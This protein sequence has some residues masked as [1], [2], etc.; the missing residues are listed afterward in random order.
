MDEKMEQNEKDFDLIEKFTR[1]EWLLHRYH[2][3]K[4][5]QHG[6]MG[7]TRRGQGRV[8][9]LLKMQ[10][11]ISQKDLLYLLNM[12]PQSL[13]ELLSKLERNGYITRTPSET[14]RRV[15]IIK[16]TQEG[17]EATKAEGQDINFDNLFECLSEEE[18]KNLS[19]YLGR[20]IETLEAKLGAEQFPLDFGPCGRGGHPFGGHFRGHHHCGGRRGA[21]GGGGGRQIGHHHGMGQ[22]WGE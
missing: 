17:A 11:E 3:Q 4:H 6:P 14:D 5:M 1:T 21:H 18:Q 13:G 7:D 9:A 22:R 16:L 2:L 15:M 8:L 19:G 12:R 20:I 10:P